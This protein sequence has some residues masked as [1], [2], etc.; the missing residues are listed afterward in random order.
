[1]KGW[2][3]FINH[4]VKQNDGFREGFSLVGVRAFMTPKNHAK[5]P[6]FSMPWTPKN[7]YLIGVLTNWTHVCRTYTEQQS[8]FI[9]IQAFLRQNL[10]ASWF[11]LEHFM[12]TPIRLCVSESLA[13]VC[14]LVRYIKLHSSRLYALW[15][16]ILIGSVRP[17]CNSLASL[18]TEDRKPQRPLGHL[19]QRAR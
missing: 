19:I 13:S 11:V 3:W 12:P 15:Y 8:M 5:T 10:V 4:E 1:M 17:N 14:K 2:N 18:D 6:N 16:K 7:C 9:P